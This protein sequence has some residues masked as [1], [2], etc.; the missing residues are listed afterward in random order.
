MMAILLGVAASSAVAQEID[1]EQTA[2]TIF[3]AFTKNHQLESELSVDTDSALAVQDFY[4]A[5]LRPTWGMDV[6]YV[7]S[8]MTGNSIPAEPITGVLLE[9]MFTGT[10]AVINRTYGVHMHASAELLVR[11]G[12]DDLNVA[13]SRQEALEAL[14]SV[15]PGVRL[16]DV[17]MD[18]DNPRGQAETAATNLEVRFCVLGGELEL[19]SDTDWISRLADFSAVLYDQNKVKI[20]EYQNSASTHP[21][22]AVLQVRDALHVRGILLREDDILALGVL[23]E[24]VAVE[25]L[26]RLRAVFHGLSDEDQVSVYMGFQ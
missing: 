16:T 5:L 24:S 19:G 9:N 7:S 4:I 11:V 2:N 18:A 10:R 8:A 13:A 25:E 15:I 12:S 3:K 14:K 20:F 22:D 26:T 1:I 6:G 23:T 21:L 17:L